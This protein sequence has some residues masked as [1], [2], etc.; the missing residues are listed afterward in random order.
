MLEVVCTYNQLC[1]CLYSTM[2]GF[3]QI[4]TK[5]LLCVEKEKIKGRKSIH[6]SNIWWRRKV[7]VTGISLVFYRCITVQYKGNINEA[8]MLKGKIVWGSVLRINNL[9]VVVISSNVNCLDH[10]EGI[11]I[12]MCFFYFYGKGRKLDIETERG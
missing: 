4:N 5:Y 7:D 11:L 12:V 2:L 3:G 9:F 1:I 10:C 8:K 6:K